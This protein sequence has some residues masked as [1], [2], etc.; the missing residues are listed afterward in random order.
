MTK[1]E[2][3]R[4]YVDKNFHRVAE[5]MP[6]EQGMQAIYM[7]SAT[8]QRKI[9]IEKAC[10][11]IEE[12]LFSINENGEYNYVANNIFG[13]PYVK[14]DLFRELRKAMEKDYES[15]M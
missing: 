3:A 2:M 12:N 4:E 14:I 5:E 6:I 13:S 9:D 15:N 7:E 8:E 11:W 10:D 1:E